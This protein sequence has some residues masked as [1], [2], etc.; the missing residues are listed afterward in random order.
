MKFTRMT[1]AAGAGASTTAAFH[2]SRVLEY[3]IH[4]K[5]HYASFETRIHK[6]KCYI[7]D[8]RVAVRRA[9]AQQSQNFHH[10]FCCVSHRAH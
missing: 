3:A 5:K 1:K 10:P 9:S 8:Y 4:T 2:L 6:F 7:T